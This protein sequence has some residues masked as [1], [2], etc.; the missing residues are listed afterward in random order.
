MKTSNAIFYLA[1]TLASCSQAHA[2][3]LVD[4]GCNMA[5]AVPNCKEEVAKMAAAQAKLP[6]LPPQGPICFT[7]GPKSYP[8]AS[9]LP[10]YVGLADAKLKEAK[11]VQENHRQD[12]ID[13][14]SW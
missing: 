9:T 1:I 13:R 4:D 11:Q 5:G 12:R 2:Q 10:D 14:G 8:T 6:P 3:A 7:C